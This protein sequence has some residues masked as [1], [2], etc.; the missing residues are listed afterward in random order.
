M[1]DRMRRAAALAACLVLALSLAGCKKDDDGGNTVPPNQIE[2]NRTEKPE[3][4]VDNA[5][6]L[7]GYT[8]EELYYVDNDADAILAANDPNVFYDG[9]GFSPRFAVNMLTTDPSGDANQGLS[10]ARFWDRIDHVQLGDKAYKI[11]DLVRPRTEGFQVLKQLMA[12]F[13]VDQ[14]DPETGA[15][16]ACLG[17]NLDDEAL[18]EAYSERED[19]DE[20]SVCVYYLDAHMSGMD[21]ELEAQCREK[22][23]EAYGDGHNQSMDGTLAVMLYYNTDGTDLF[24]AIAISAP[25]YWD[26]YENFEKNESNS[27]RHDTTACHM[28]VDEDT[29]IGFVNQVFIRCD[30]DEVPTK[31]AVPE[32]APGKAEIKDGPIGD[33]SAADQK[34]GSGN[35]GQKNDPAS[36]SDTDGGTDSGLTVEPGVKTSGN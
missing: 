9:A 29:A 31:T 27:L 11:T 15:L 24:Y 19:Y 25:S 1:K 35:A 33:G 4:F 10:L 26:S 6:G 17:K 3:G 30:Q 5:E 22:L 13:G 20:Y 14:Y 36:G 2:D 23:T 18:R 21:P 34:A 12:D 28:L 32:K 7:D 8:D 16:K